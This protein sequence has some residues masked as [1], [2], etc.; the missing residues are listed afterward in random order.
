MAV[1]DQKYELVSISKLKP[2]PKNPR[3]GVV[4]VIQES[5]DANGFYGALVVQ[6]STNYILVGNHRF[7]A[8]RET[9]ITEL[10]VVFIDVD[11]ERATKILLADNRANDKAE[12]DDKELADLLSS[13]S[14]TSDLIG[15]LYDES[16]LDDLIAGLSGDESETEPGKNHGSLSDRFGIPPFSVLNA[17]EGWWQDRKRAWLSL[18]IQSELGRG[19]A[20]PREQP[21]DNGTGT[22][23]LSKS[24]ARTFGQDL[25]RGEHIVGSKKLFAQTWSNPNSTDDVS[26]KILEAQPQSGT[27]IFDPVL[28]EIA[29]RWFCPPNGKVLDPFAGGSVR[30]IVASMLGHDYTGIELRAEQIE[31][32]RIQAKTICKDHAPVWIEGDSTN[33]EQLAPGEY[34]FILTCPPYADLEVYS[35]NPLDLSTMPYATFLESYRA[36]IASCVKMLKD[37]RFAMIV[38]GDARDKKGNYYGLPWHTV[39]AFQDAGM[40]L[41]NE[42]VLVTAVGSLPIRVGKQFTASRKLGKTHQNVLIFVKGDGKKATQAIGECEFGEFTEETQPTEESSTPWLNEDEAHAV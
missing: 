21:R 42:A 17:R 32:N 20:D 27:S 2:H 30:G 15:S 26:L 10:P 41:Y 6:K 4:S 1:L 7:K 24:D 19:G 40:K 12:Y 39:Q 36:I 8:A 5:I 38:I 14:N 16:D 34:D 11:D 22:E 23:L 29:Y 9:G 28:C 13:L 37:D 33:A 25:M 3:R 35:D 31:S 18:G